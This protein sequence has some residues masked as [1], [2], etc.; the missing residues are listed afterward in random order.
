MKLKTVLIILAVLVLFIFLLRACVSY[1]KRDVK[2][3][4]E[5]ITSSKSDSDDF[6]KDVDFSTGNYAIILD[7]ETPPILID[8]INALETNK[9]RIETDISWLNYLP[10][11]GG[12]AHGIRVFEKNKLV[13]SR[14]ARKFKTFE[15]G[16]LKEYGQPVEFKSI[17]E[18][19]R[20]FLKKKD[21][22]ENNGDVYISRATEVDTQGFEYR[23]TLFCPSLLISEE[24]TLFNENRYGKEFAHRIAEG[25]SSMSGF[26]KGDNASNSIENSPLL[27][28]KKDGATLYLRNSETNN[29]LPLS[30]YE[31]HGAQLIFFC[32]AA[33]YEEIQA[34]DF[35]P[36]FEREGLSEQEIRDLIREKIGPDNEEVQLDAV[37]NSMFESDFSIGKLYEQKYELR[38][39]QLVH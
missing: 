10:G 34:H 3:S 4:I 22:L 27:L 24:D 28:V 1:V 33:F 21:S 11:E 13:H 6:F 14:S 38:Y 39:F 23:F 36:Y 32:T 15:V 29:T 17:Y 30:G 31:L 2:H 25:L 26:R 20:S 8:D 37:Y 7:D 16:T 19:R 12:G 35:S 9:K 5:K 18:P